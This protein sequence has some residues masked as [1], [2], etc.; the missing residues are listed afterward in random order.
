MQDVL[1]G[2]PLGALLAQRRPLGMGILKLTPDSFSDGGQFLDPAV[3]I[4]H[5]RKMVEDGADILDI[6]AESTR[7]Y[8]GM[9]PVSLEDEIGRLQP[10]LPEIA[11]L[12]RPVSI[13]TVKAEVAAFALAHGASILNDVWG[14]QR[15]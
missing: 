6:G 12:Q 3:A 11:R 4:A 5:A 7:P 2:N 8:G 10:V 9:Q 1:T 15:D 14:L 13:D